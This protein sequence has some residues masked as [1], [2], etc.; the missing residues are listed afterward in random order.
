V[1]G[2]A[3]QKQA[4]SRERAKDEAIRAVAVYLNS[5]SASTPGIAEARWRAL[6]RLA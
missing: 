2:V 5:F 1:H 4:A 3:Q 6:Q